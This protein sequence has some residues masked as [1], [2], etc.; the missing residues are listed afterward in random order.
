MMTCCLEAPAEISRRVTD[1]REALE[2]EKDL[3][4]SEDE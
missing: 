4:K 1:Y 3:F 2:R